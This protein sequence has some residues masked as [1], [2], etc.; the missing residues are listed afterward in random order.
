M[1]FVEMPY[2][3]E[4]ITIRLTLLDQTSLPDDFFEHPFHHSSDR[5]VLDETP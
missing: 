2:G 1:R 3:P 5:T 4:Q